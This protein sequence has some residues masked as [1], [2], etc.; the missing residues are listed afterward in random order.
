MKTSTVLGNFCYMSGEKGCEKQKD[1]ALGYY[2]LARSYFAVGD[3][4]RAI[5]ASNHSCLLEPENPSGL[6]LHAEICSNLGQFAIA[7]ANL[8]RAFQIDP[9][10]KSVSERIDELKSMVAIFKL[11][12]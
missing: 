2:L 6:R 9:F 8:R 7:I 12:L 3:F 4:E 1:Y 5:E 10:G 11:N